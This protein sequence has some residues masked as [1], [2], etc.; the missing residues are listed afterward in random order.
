MIKKIMC[1][2]LFVLSATS[3]ASN[4]IRITN[5]TNTYVVMNVAIQY[6]TLHGRFQEGNICG[7]VNE[8]APQTGGLTIAPSASASITLPTA[9]EYEKKHGCQC[10]DGEAIAIFAAIEHGIYRYATWGNYSSRPNQIDI[11]AGKG[12]P[13]FVGSA[14]GCP[15]S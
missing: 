11:K 4:T 14:K 5:K 3:Y 1:C 12:R 13:C 8:P 9:Q 2:L 6:C 15:N 7:S 10:A